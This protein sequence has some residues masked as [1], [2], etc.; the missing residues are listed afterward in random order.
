MKTKE[1]L[2]KSDK[3]LEQMIRTTR[4]EINKA[5]VELRTSQVSNV[6]QI[7][8]L[9]RQL[10]RV[11]T[12]MRQREIAAELTKEGKEATQTETKQ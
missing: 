1:I 10:A 8:G 4:D 2:A 11:M 5:H 7:H 6:K 12:I 3:E 9:R